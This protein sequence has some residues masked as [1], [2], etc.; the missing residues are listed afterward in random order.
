[1]IDGVTLAACAPLTL[2]QAYT[3][4]ALYNCSGSPSAIGRDRTRDLR[5]RRRDEAVS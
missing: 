5:I 4:V 1:M 2:V 3:K